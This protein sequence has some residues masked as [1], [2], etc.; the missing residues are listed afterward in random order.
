MGKV[1]SEETKYKLANDLGF[2][3]KVS[4]HD[5]SDVT[6]G[7]VGSM[8]REAIKRGEQ[9]IAEEAKA[10]GAVHQNVK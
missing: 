5:W 2:G 8:V 10:N 4:D 3:D 6:T 7:E 1:M 9:A